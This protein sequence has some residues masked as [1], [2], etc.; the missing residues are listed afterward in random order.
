MRARVADEAAVAIGY[1][2]RPSKPEA[3]ACPKVNIGLCRDLPPRALRVA[4]A[5][6]VL[7][8]RPAGLLRR[9]RDVLSDD[10]NGHK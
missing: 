9:N 2:K 10:D 4:Y 6:S 3:V 1:Y 5:A 7:N 8:C